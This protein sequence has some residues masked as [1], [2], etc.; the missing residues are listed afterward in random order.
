M[1]MKARFEHSTAQI[2]ILKVASHLLSFYIGNIVLAIENAY[3]H[4]STVD[5]ETKI[6]LKSVADPCSGEWGLALATAEIRR[7]YLRSVLNK[8]MQAYL[9]AEGV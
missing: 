6:C 7:E 5:V 8:N 3:W 4:T 9:A 1:K 2:K